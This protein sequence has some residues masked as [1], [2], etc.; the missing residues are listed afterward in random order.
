MNYPQIPGIEA[1]YSKKIL[2][3]F[4]KAPPDTEV[5][6]FG[7][8]AKGN[9]REGSDIDLAIKGQKIGISDRNDW[10][11]AYAE[12]NLPWILDILIYGMIEEPE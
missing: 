4:Q 11:S 9:Y 10:L 12:L 7:S 1:I 3:I 8:R 6:L 2:E 5:I